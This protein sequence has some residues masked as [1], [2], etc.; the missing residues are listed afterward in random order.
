[1]DEVQAKVALVHDEERVLS[2]NEAVVSYILVI[3]IIFSSNT[4]FYIKES[5]YIHIFGVIGRSKLVN[6]VSAC[7]WMLLM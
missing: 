4:V 5:T 1:M 6:T 2:E 3:Q 7:Y